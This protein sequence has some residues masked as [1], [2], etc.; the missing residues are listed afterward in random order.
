MNN[1][2]QTQ[3]KRCK[4]YFG[5]DSIHCAVHPQGKETP[6]CNDW[7][8]EPLLQKLAANIKSVA[9]NF[10]SPI[11][12]AIVIG[13]ASTI[14]LGYGLKQNVPLAVNAVTLSH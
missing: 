13:I 2:Q 7:Q 14:T 3:C 5:K 1:P 4:Y 11:F 6:D 8:K 9:N 10:S 12:A